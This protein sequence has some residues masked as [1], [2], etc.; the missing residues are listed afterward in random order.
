MTAPLSI[1]GI[2]LRQPVVLAPMSGVTDWPFRRVVGVLVRRG[3]VP[4]A[5][6]A[7]RLWVWGA[8]GNRE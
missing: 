7:R 2:S 5:W 6:G 8:P 1:G 4:P 3:V